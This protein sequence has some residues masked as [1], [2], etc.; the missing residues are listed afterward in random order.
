MMEEHEDVDANVTEEEFNEIVAK[1]KQKN[2][3]SYDFLTKSGK[4]FQSSI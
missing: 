2:K 3:K 1:F 4:G